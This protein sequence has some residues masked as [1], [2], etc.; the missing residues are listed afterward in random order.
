MLPGMCGWHL[1]MRSMCGP[2]IT[3]PQAGH[4]KP[5]TGR[6][7]SFRTSDKRL[8]TVRSLLLCRRVVQPSS[9]SAEE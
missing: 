5:V 7:L 2:Y 9:W 6:C 1:E 8:V 3:G 4:A